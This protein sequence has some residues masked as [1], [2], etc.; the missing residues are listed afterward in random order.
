MGKDYYKIL[1]IDRSAA[2]DDIKKA[3]KKM[4]C[5]MFLSCITGMLLTSNFTGTE[6][7]S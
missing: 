6:M 5:L 4:V 3:Y 2:D 1:G 7:A